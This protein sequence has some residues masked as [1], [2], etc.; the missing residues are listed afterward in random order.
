MERYPRSVA[1]LFREE[2]RDG[3]PEERAVKY[4]KTLCRTLEDL[5][6]QAILHRDLLG[7]ITLL[8]VIRT[9]F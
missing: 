5:H 1:D 4:L 2:F 3:I 8:G 7:V 9:F 6:A